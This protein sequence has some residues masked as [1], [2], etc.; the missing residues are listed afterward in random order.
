MNP[1]ADPHSYQPNAQDARLIASANMVIV[2]GAGYDEWA[3]ELLRGSPS[4]GRTVLDAG[5]LLRVPAGANPHRWY[6]PR[7]VEAVAS[8]IAADYQRIDPA[9]AAYFARRSRELRRRVRAL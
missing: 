5:E 2:N 1:D 8:A 7:D 9:D 3:H 4:P 6:F